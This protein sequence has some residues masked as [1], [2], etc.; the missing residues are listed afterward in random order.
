ME[1]LD[2]GGYGGGGGEEMDPRQ[3]ALLAALSQAGRKRGIKER[4]LSYF[5]MEYYK[6]WLIFSA[7]LAIAAFHL[8]PR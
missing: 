6:H 5:S 8:W 7:I 1:G 3:L 4:L 2:G